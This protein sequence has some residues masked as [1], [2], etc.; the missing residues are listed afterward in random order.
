MLWHWCISV[1]MNIEEDITMPRKITG[2]PQCNHVVRHNPAWARHSLTST[3]DLR[4]SIG[5]NKITLRYFFPTSHL[6]MMH[7]CYFKWIKP[8][9]IGY[10]ITTHQILKEALKRKLLKKVW[11]CFWHYINTTKITCKVIHPG[12]QTSKQDRRWNAEK[13]SAALDPWIPTWLTTSPANHKPA[14]F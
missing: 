9:S 1:D 8:T 7:L 11:L 4:Q 3:W 2:A 14:N 6:C 12:K 10:G 5:N 13:P